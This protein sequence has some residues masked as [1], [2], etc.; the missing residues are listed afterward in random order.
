[1]SSVC[2]A[3]R[4]GPREARSVVRE[5][6]FELQRMGLGFRHDALDFAFDGMNLGRGRVGF[7]RNSAPYG[8]DACV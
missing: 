2:S 4:G 6:L 3:Q 1:M 7:V 5:G 8:I